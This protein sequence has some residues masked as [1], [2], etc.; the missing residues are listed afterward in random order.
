[1]LRAR[2]T[3]N[4]TSHEIGFRGTVLGT[5]IHYT[6]LAGRGLWQRRGSSH[7]QFELSSP[8]MTHEDVT[9]SGER[10]TGVKNNAPPPFRE[11]PQ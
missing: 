8:L 10:Q 4:A 6:G 11:E 1:M 9:G 7:R 5:G 2:I 3:P